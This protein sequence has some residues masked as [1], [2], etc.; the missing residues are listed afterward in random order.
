MN[1]APEKSADSGSSAGA[2]SFLLST[3]AACHESCTMKSDLHDGF[4]AS[5]DQSAQT[6]VENSSSHSVRIPMTENAAIGRSRQATL[7]DSPRAAAKAI[8]PAILSRLI[9]SVVHLP[10][11]PMIHWMAGKDRSAAP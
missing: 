1:S 9:P 7:P 10:L 3:M 6:S 4:S 11:I 2:I 8:S 5:Q